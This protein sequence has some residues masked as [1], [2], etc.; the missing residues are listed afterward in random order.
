MAFGEFSKMVVGFVK[1]IGFK[2]SNRLFVFLGIIFTMGGCGNIVIGIFLWEAANRNCETINLK[3]I[4]KT[5]I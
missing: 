3:I 2:L 4:M 5:K 1:E